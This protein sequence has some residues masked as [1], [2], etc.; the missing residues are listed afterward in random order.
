MSKNA[1]MQKEWVK[2]QTREH[3]WEADNRAQEDSDYAAQT[4]A[5][6]AMRGM[7][8]DEATRKKNCM[9]KEM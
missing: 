8:E 6:T 3:N 1:A 7:L 9:L 4:A 2:E 5:I